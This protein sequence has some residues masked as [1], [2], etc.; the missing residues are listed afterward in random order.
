MKPNLEPAAKKPHLALLLATGIGLGYLPLAPGTWGSLGGLVLTLAC[1]APFLSAVLLPLWRAAPFLVFLVASTKEIVLFVEIFV[2]VVVA[3]VG[4]WAS[5]RAAEFLG[6]RD[7]QQIVI[8]EVSG[9][10]ITLL[11]GLGASYHPLYVIRNPD[12]VGFSR[13]FVTRVLNWKYLLLGFILFRVF[14]IWKPFPV[15]QAEKLPGGWG[16]MADD[17]VAAIY[18]ALGLWLARSLGL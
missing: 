4:T 5:G 11:L 17:W 1:V 14:D 2:T 10:A 18:A 13:L 15:R 8:D 16:I 6:T 9:M 7:P 3:A 12:F